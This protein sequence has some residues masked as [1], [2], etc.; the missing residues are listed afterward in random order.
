MKSPRALWAAAVLLAAACFGGGWVARSVTTH[1]PSV[2]PPLRLTDDQF[3]YISP[4]L[5]CNSAKAFPQDAPIISAAQ[6]AIARHVSQGDIANAS[7]YFADFASG[8][9]ASVNGADTYYPSSL[10]KVPILIAYEEL[11]EQSSTLMDRR[12]TFPAGSPDLN[13]EQEIR[14]EQAVKPG[15]TYA[16]RELLDDMIRYSD[17]NAAALLYDLVDPGDL[18][19]IYRDLQLPVNDHVTSS[20]L[21]FMTPQQYGI[22]F[23]TLYNA[24]YLPRADSNDALALLA[25]TDFTEGIVAGVPSGTAVAHKFGIVSFYDGV[26]VTKRELHDCG[27]V[28]A[29]GDAYLLCVMT[30]GT[31]S[32]GSQERSIADISSAVYQAVEGGR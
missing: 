14:P 10:G 17:N 21:D 32:L 25:T 27:I 8:Q 4:L 30:R 29:P 22:L 28:Y 1:A 2:P 15:G 18:N 9:W 24:T 6:T 12:V 20:T 16:V 31:A 26:T 7:V 5:A 11:A 23:R 19:E 3:R 13:A